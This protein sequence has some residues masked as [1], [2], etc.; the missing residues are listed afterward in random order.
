MISFFAQLM[1]YM[2][3]FHFIKLWT[4]RA[5]SESHLSGFMYVIVIIKST[6]HASFSME[7]VR[8][9]KIESWKH[10]EINEGYLVC[11]HSLDTFMCKKWTS[12][13]YETCT[14]ILLWMTDVM[15]FTFESEKLLL[16][17]LSCFLVICCNLTYAI[18]TVDDLLWWKRF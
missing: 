1:I 15:K 13:S 8:E 11:T 2:I 6:R 16:L 14:F 9:R 3:D 5:F 17:S 10:A 12:L 18:T 7:W 4:K